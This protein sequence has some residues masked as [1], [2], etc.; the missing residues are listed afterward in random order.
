MIE[1]WKDRRVT[2]MGLGRFGG[3]V[4]AAR[5]LARGGARVLVTDRAPA[6]KL[7]SSLNEIA[8]FDVALRLGEHVERDFRETDLVVVSPAVPDSSPFLQAAR[9]AGVPVTTEMNLFVERCP[10][11]CIGVTGSVG[12][13]TVTA[14]I[15]HVLERTPADRRAWVGGNVGR[16]LLD[17]LGTITADD[18][19]VLELS[20]FQLER[21]PAVRWSPHV[22]VITNLAPNHLDWHGTYA[23]YAAAKLNIVRFQDRDRDAIVLGDNVELRRQFEQ[24]CGEVAGTWVYGL[25]GDSPIA[26][27]GKRRARWNRLQLA[28]PGRHNRENAAATLTV[29]HAMGLD[30]DAAA[31]TLATFEGLPHRLQRVTTRA[32]VTYYN[33][34]KSTTPQAAVTAMGA[35]DGP[36]LIILG[37]Y[38]KGIDLSVAA[39]SAARRAKFAACI[40]QTGPAL[41]KAIRAAGGSAEL[42]ADL[43]TAVAACRRRAGP[44]DAI[45]LSPG[46]A[47]WD[48]FDDYRQRGDEFARLARA[49]AGKKS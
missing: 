6:A 35:L 23:A 29:A 9:D 8:D 26:T 10:A 48:M 33:D 13:S 17:E 39:E 3:G 42:C 20:S 5:W 24:T 40:G 43:A 45:L 34:S 30:V 47:S 41:V 32:G 49:E 15:G 22:A 1:N 14:M 19:V 7:R 11:R 46:C 16:S 31:A 18:V 44:G 12:K 4:G 2:I 25:D 21:T 28:V 27:C 37:G 38:D 36:L